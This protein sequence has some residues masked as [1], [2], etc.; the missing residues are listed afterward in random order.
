MSQ[1]QPPCLHRYIIFVPVLV[2]RSLGLS[3]VKYSLRRLI[4]IRARFTFT[5]YMAD[6][7]LGTA[8]LVLASPG[9]IHLCLE[10][11][12]FL[13]QRIDSYR[14]IREIERL[15]RFIVDLIQGELH[16]LLTF[17]ASIQGSQPLENQTL[18][19]FDHLRL[20]LANVVTLLP[21]DPGTWGKLKFSFAKQKLLDNACRELEQWYIRFLRRA[22]VLLVFGGAGMAEFQPADMSSTQVLSRVQ[23]IRRAV[24]DPLPETGVAS[25]QLEAFDGSAALRQ[26]DNSGI[27]VS[28]P[29]GGI[30]EYRTY[31]GHSTS[32]EINETRSLVR[33]IAAALKKSDPS[34]MGLLLCKGFSA[35]PLHYRFALH[36]DYPS[37]KT[38][39]H[40]LQHLLTHPSN[41]SPG[42]RHSM[43]NRIDLARKLASAVLY[44]HSCGFVHKN[45]R[46]ENILIFD[47]AAPAG[48]DAALLSYPNVIGEPFLI[49]FDS[50]RRATAASNMIRV[51]EWKKNIYLHPD[52]HRMAPGDEFTTRHDIYSLGVVLL[53]I[54][55]WST[56]T[57]Q[58]GIG[59]YLWET[60]DN[61]QMLRSPERLQTRYIEI[62]KSQ[63]PRILG[64]KYRD[65]VVSCLEGLRDEEEGGL[66]NDQDGIV[67][68]SA[69][70]TQIMS[71]LEEIS[72]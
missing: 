52:R 7:A 17:F 60:R 44:M 66:L 70:I 63:V 14:N 23:H 29:D 11:G 42:I 69:Y 56:F 49:G 71:R 9:V 35:E 6:V 1:P 58:T 15:D 22:V 51:E 19:L 68:G 65:V 57:H 55:L 46:P 16:I 10:Y 2:Y 61:V 31:D 41:Q 33:D 39:P 62:A 72:L 59:K 30:V 13:K 25:L 21:S 26:V 48:T 32:K 36:F 34:I 53:E 67:V 45:I 50:V 64:D 28:E 24:L 12:R 43:S 38:K 40:T 4:E 37:G 5:T 18:T 27:Y 47:A 3:L 54:S 20:L 8:G